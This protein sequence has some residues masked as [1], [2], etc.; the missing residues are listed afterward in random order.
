M[1][2]TANILDTLKRYLKAKGIT[3]KQLA[4]DMN[5]SEA[6][7]KR[8]FSKQTFSLARLEEV[9][10][11][12]DIDFYD[13]ALM[14]KQRSQETPDVLTTEQE[15]VL[16]DDPKMFVFLY[17]LINGWPVSLIIEE[18]DF[19][20]VEAAQLLR[21]L[22]ELGVLERHPKD[23]I[24]LLIRKNEFWRP[25]GPI[26]Q[27]YNPLFIDDFMESSFS[28]PNECFVFIPGQFSE[29]SLKIIRKKIDN[30]LKEYNQLAE[31]DSALPIKGRY[32]TGLLIGFRPWVF[33]LIANLRRTK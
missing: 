32:S 5:L 26:W 21:R 14:D 2:L 20:E 1:N 11:V 19:T 13:L 24:R 27:K 29:A 23:R 7:V 28:R 17:F 3:Y 10:R 25:N 31:M 33:T 8:L 6:S 16:V 18:Y 15:Q 4:S 30:L 12:L 9:C 22:E